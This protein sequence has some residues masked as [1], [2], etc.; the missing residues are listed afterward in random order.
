ML[1]AHGL[2]KIS[3][4]E[5]TEDDRPRLTVLLHHEEG[6]LEPFAPYVGDDTVLREALDK[7]GKR[8]DAPVVEP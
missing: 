1:D 6:V 5:M 8:C 2:Q 3:I 4:L 7:L